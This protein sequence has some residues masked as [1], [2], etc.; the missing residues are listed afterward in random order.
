MLKVKWIDT[1]LDFSRIETIS[2]LIA[3]AAQHRWQICQMDVKSIFLNGYLEEEVCLEQPL[4][5][6]VRGHEGEKSM[7]YTVWSNHQWLDIAVL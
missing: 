6:V 2:F 4:D 3:L 1:R 5:Y 7:H